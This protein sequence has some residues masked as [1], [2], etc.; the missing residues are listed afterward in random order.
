MNDRG[1]VYESVEACVD[2][3]L[4]R[5]GKR[6]V[7]ATPLG[8]GEA[9]HI[10]NELCRRAR[11]DRSLQLRIITALTLE[12]PRWKNALEQRFIEPLS[13]WLFGSY[14]DLRYALARHTGGLPPHVEVI[15]FV[16]PPG[17]LLN[18]EQER[19][20]YISSNYTHV[21]RDLCD[22]G[23]NVLAQL[24][25]REDGDRVAVLGEVNPQ[26]PFMHGDAALQ[27]VL[28]RR[29]GD[30]R[31]DKALFEAPIAEG[32]VS[33]KLTA[34]DVGRL[35]TWGVLRDDL[36]FRYR[37]IR[38]PGAR[39]LPVDLNSGLMATVTGAV[40]SDG[41]DDGRVLSG[42]GGQY[43]FVTMAHA[44]EDGRSILMIRA[45]RERDGEAVSNVVWNYGHTT[46]PRHLRDIVVTEYG[47]ADLRGKRDRDVVEAMIAVADSRF[48]E[49]LVREA[50]RSLKLPKGY[51]VPERFRNNYP[52]WLEAL[53][54]PYRERG[55]FAE[56]P[57]GTDYT[58][59]EIVLAK[60]L[61]ALARKLKSREFSFTDLSHLGGIVSVPTVAE[62]YLQRLGM[63]DPSS[64]AEIIMQKA[65]LF[66]LELIDAI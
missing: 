47:I 31:V 18:N 22:F 38:D 59:E 6:V 37:R 5:V 63:K 24:I 55:L 45:A 8:L 39:A 20:N 1:K 44:L 49:K 9:N 27:R 53:L 48:Q 66:G 51:R 10:V 58:E 21:V 56:F 61:R 12:R 16:Y 41:V 13:E 32:A 4:R 54:A 15:E 43:N 30:D 3:T 50:V 40:V 42:V 33:S 46:I 19:G 14:R 23:V 2:D 34:D 57:C 65:A 52:D 28:N 36:E 26:L 25:A 35:Q 64:I 11:E 29:L 17:S 60:A 7:L 62:P